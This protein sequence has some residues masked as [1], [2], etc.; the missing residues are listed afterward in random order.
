MILR[1]RSILLLLSAAVSSCQM[2]EPG[3][4]SRG[5]NLAVKKT[6]LRPSFEQVKGRSYTEV[7]R[8]FNNGLSFHYTGFQLEPEW[9]L[10]FTSD[11]TVKIYSPSKKAYIHYPMYYSHA[12]VF[13]FAR[14]WLRIKKLSRDSLVFELLEVENKV[15]LKKPQQVYMT[16]YSDRYIHNVLKTD[17]ATLRKPTRKDSLYIRRRADRAI[18]DPEQAFP[19][20]QPVRMQSSSPFLTVKKV[21]EQEDVLANIERMDTYMLPR[22]DIRIDRAYRDFGYYFSVRVDEKGR[23]EFKRFLQQVQPEFLEARTRVVRGIIDVYLKN[24]VKVTPGTTLGYRHPSVVSL[25]VS[26]KK[27]KSAGAGT[28]S[29]N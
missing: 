4:Q 23:I 25:Y 15:I 26:G 17:A 20:R 14:E 28:F 19:A 3:D 5:K 24:L 21:H 29:G 9:K 13:N 12:T 18:A 10:T 2:Q 11:S 8:A 22:Y 16:F 27:G 7:R 6:V 1:F